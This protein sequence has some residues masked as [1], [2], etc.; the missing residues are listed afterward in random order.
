M[1]LD[2]IFAQLADEFASHFPLALRGPRTVGREAEFPIVDG[3]GDA[4]DVRGLWPHL[5]AEGGLTPVPDPSTPDLIVALKGADYTYA[6]EVGLGTVEVNTRPCADLFE[7]QT[8]HEAAVTR[9]VRAASALNWRILGYGIQPQTPAHLDL[10]APKPRYQTLWEAMGHDWLPYTVTASDQLQVDIC[11]PELLTMLNV[12]NLI[13]PTLVA[14]C[15]NSPVAA[16]RP[17]PFCSARE[18]MMA[19]IRAQEH[20]HGLPAHFFEN[21]TDFVAS[22]SQ[23]SHLIQ[24]TQTGGYTTAR[25][26]FT[27]Y[28]AREGAD[29]PAFLFHEHYIWNSARIRTS[30]ATV[31][32]RPACQQPWA[33]HMLPAALSLGLIEAADEVAAYL[34]AVFADDAWTAMQSYMRRAIRDGLAATQPIPGFLAEMIDL[35]AEGLDKRGLGEAIFLAPARQRLASGENPAQVARRIFA[36]E[37]IAGLLDH[38]ALTKN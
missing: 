4:A 2:P 19:E 13:A 7:L 27:D 32:V 25:G 14:L 5:L 21:L 18:G 34:S 10:M 38:V 30:Y 1:N 22:L 37:G 9:L 33:S 12:G 15:A 20:R 35:A 11:R 26:N 29:F 28:L 31:E 3:D 23:E 16:G 17:T 36:K 24:R 6:M 8:V